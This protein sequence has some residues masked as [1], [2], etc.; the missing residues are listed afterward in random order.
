MAASLLPRLPLA[1]GGRRGSLGGCLVLGPRRPVPV[2]QLTLLLRIRVPARRNA[3]SFHLS[4]LSSDLPVIPASP[5]VRIPVRD[6][7]A[8][9]SARAEV[10][11]ATGRGS[12]REC[13]QSETGA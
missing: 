13:G 9:V 8:A 7:C 4:C 2:A 6:R 11:G 12:R 5:P 1:A 10:P 3:H